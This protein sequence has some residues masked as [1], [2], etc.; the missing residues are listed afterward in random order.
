MKHSH[1]LH[2]LLVAFAD[3]FLSSFI[4]MMIDPIYFICPYVSSILGSVAPA[5]RRSPTKFAPSPYPGQFY[6]AN[7]NVIK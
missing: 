1:F 2:F 4:L 5:V 3:I 6:L 7:V